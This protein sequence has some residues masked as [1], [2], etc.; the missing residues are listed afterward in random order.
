MPQTIKISENGKYYNQADQTGSYALLGLTAGKKY[1]I[2]ISVKNDKVESA[3]ITRIVDVPANPFAKGS[4]GTVVGVMIAI[5]ISKKY[6]FKKRHKGYKG[7]P[8]RKV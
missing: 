8:K 5:I 7:L 2:K 6:N 1:Q 3:P 4:T